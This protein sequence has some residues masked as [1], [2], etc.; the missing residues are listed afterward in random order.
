MNK[1]ALPNHFWETDFYTP[2]EK[3][4]AALLDNAALVVYK[5][6]LLRAQ[7]FCTPLLL[8]CEKGQH[9]PALVVYKNLVDISDIII[10]LLGR[11][12]GRVQGVGR[13]EGGPFF[14][15]ITGGGGGGYSPRRGGRGAGSASA[16]NG[17][18]GGTNQ[19]DACIT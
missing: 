3:G 5:I 15:K 7:D 16:G 2:P 12:E 9:L 13:G 10:F 18:G 11:G 8:T 1:K 4:G 14:E 19:Q 17:G 6:Q